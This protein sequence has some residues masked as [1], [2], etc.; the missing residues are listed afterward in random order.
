[1]PLRQAMVFPMSEGP[2]LGLLVASHDEPGVLYRVAEVIFRHGANIEYIA[3]GA[4]KDGVAELQL[5][6][7]GAADETSLVADL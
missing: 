4:R 3:G 7:S 2:L 5:E 1:M 6:V